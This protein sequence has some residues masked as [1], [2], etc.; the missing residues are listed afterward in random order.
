M[1][2]TLGQVGDSVN[3]LDFTLYKGERYHREGILMLDPS[4]N[5]LTPPFHFMLPQM[6]LQKPGQ[7]RATPSAHSP[8]SLQRLLLASLI[9]WREEPNQ[10]D[11]WMK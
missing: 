3:L 9:A 2:Y 6:C 8:V 5:Q 1:K 4:P 10:K 11:C 7:R